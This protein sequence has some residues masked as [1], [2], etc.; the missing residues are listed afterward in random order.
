[1]SNSHVIV[2]WVLGNLVALC[3]LIVICD[4]YSLGLGLFAGAI[5]SALSDIRRYLADLN[6]KGGIGHE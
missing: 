5:C 2:P 4:E 1:M 6:Q 3:L